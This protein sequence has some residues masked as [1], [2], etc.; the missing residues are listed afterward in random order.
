M[1]NFIPKQY[2]KNPIDFEKSDGIDTLADNFN[3]TL[4]IFIYTCI[5]PCKK[6]GRFSS[7][8]HTYIY[9]LFSSC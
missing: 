6:M 5:F 2:I 7:A 3:I 4:S 8:P 9:V 1:L